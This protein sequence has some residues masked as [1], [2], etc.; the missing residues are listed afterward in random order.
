MA[1]LFDFENGVVFAVRIH[2]GLFVVRVLLP[3]PVNYVSITIAACGQFQLCLP[4]AAVT[5]F[6]HFRKLRLPIIKI[7]RNLHTLGTRIQRYKNYRVV[8]LID[9]IIIGQFFFQALF[10]TMTAGS[11]FSSSSSGCTW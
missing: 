10:A 11:I 4:Y 2:F 7:S 9:A 1:V 3:V 6:L 5:D 8:N